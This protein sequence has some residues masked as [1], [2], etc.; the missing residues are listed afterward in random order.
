MKMYRVH[1]QLFAKEKKM[2][3]Y[4]TG[5]YVLRNY[6]EGSTGKL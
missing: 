2:K 4:L 1:N 3:I 6:Q 5:L